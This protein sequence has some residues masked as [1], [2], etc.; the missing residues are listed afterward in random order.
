MQRHIKDCGERLHETARGKLLG[1]KRGIHTVDSS[2][3]ASSWHEMASHSTAEA[4]SGRYNIDSE[5]MNK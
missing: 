4:T 2:A 1:L 5:Q 3:A